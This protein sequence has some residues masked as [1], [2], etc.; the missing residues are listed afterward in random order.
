MCDLRCGNVKQICIR[1]SEDEYV[2]DIRSA[3]AFAED[4][5]VLSSS[6]IDEIV[7]DETTRIERYTSQSWES[8]RANTL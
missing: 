8:L 4:E 3:M 5:R 7:L 2:S 6:S 1:V